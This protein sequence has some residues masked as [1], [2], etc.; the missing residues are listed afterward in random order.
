MGTV[1]HPPTVAWAKVRAIGDMAAPE[2]ATPCRPRWQ[3]AGRRRL[4][5]W[6]PAVC[7]RGP[8]SRRAEA[9]ALAEPVEVSM[10]RAALRESRCALTN[11]RPATGTINAPSDA[12]RA[13]RATAARRRHPLRPRRLRPSYTRRCLRWLA[14]PSL[15]LAV[16]PWLS[17]ATTVMH[18]LRNGSSGRRTGVWNNMRKC[19]R[20]LAVQ[21]PS[22]QMSLKVTCGMIDRHKN[23][24]CNMQTSRWTFCT[25]SRRDIL[26]DACSSPSRRA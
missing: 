24:I 16:A 23:A 21:S 19:A 10:V 9:P 18:P 11:L 1:R 3:R 12:G 15:R 13:G 25:H 4:A 26:P 8:L 2:Q 22:A 14:P 17:A 6:V 5:G 7:R 20:P